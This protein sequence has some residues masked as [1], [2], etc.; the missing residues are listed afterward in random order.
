MGM[1]CWIGINSIIM[2]GS[3]ICENLVIGEGIIVTD[4]IPPNFL[5]LGRPAKPIKFF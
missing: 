5:S 3:V 4:V 2:A 1:N